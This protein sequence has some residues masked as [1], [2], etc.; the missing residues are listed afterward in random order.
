MKLMPER[1]VRGVVATAE[2]L[3]ALGLYD[4]ADALLTILVMRW[5][6][7]EWGDPQSDRLGRVCRRMGLRRAR[8]WSKF[9]L[10]SRREI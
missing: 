9:I 6:K 5:I 1:K 8:R 10:A 7:V 2:M 4:E 3:K